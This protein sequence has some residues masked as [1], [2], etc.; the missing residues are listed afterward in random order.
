MMGEKVKVKALQGEQAGHWP[1][2]D[3]GRVEI[4]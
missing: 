4:P 1:K 3:M 2:K